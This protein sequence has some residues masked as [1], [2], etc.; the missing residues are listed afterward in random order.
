MY[1][2]WNC[3]LKFEEPC[4]EEVCLED[5][6]GVGSMFPDRHYTLLATCPRCELD[7][8]EEYS[9]EED[10]DEYEDEYDE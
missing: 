7:D 10:I 9:D 5:L 8:I 1:K 3:G 6:Y 2:C 4:Y